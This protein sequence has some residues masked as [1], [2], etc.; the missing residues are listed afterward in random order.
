ML[1]D[2]RRD[3]TPVTVR[4]EDCPMCGA[5]MAAD[6]EVITCSEC[7]GEGCTEYCIPGG[8]GTACV[9]CESD[10]DAAEDDDA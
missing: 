3:D 4:G 10:G 6:D 9:D 1:S 2:P 8:R 7:G 5:A